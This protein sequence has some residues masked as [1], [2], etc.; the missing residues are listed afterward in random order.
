M[1]T[2]YDIMFDN[3]FVDRRLRKCFHEYLR[4]YQN[5]EALQFLIDV[6][7]FI[8]LIA[9]SSKYTSAKFIMLEYIQEGSPSEVNVS[10][11]Q[12][13]ALNEEFKKCS[14]SYCPNSLFDEV[15][16]TVYVGLKEDCFGSFVNS[17]EFSKH[18]KQTLKTD[19]NYLS[20][21]GSLKRGR[22]ILKELAKSKD[23]RIGDLDFEFG[24]TNLNCEWTNVFSTH[25]YSV[26]VSKE[27]SPS[28]FKKKKE[29]MTLPFS[30]QEVYDI[31]ICSET[32]QEILSNQ[33]RT[34]T[35]LNAVECNKYKAV[36]VHAVQS[37][38][39]LCKNIDAS[40]LCC[41]KRLD[42]GSIIHVEKSVCNPDVPE[43]KNLVRTSALTTQ[44]FENIEGGCRYTDVTDFDCGFT[45][46]LI[47]FMVCCLAK[48][49]LTNFHVILEAGNRRKEIGASGPDNL[50]MSCSLAHYDGFHVPNTK[51]S[52]C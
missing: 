40:L 44:L 28:G 32:N 29:V 41:S 50:L 5:Q 35:Y 51:S 25:D 47:N 22:Y 36:T 15:R 43:S 46:S 49:H 3:V 33:K 45:P 17:K 23:L 27:K 6:S 12:K 13:A 14:D 1:P 11:A 10:C 52:S 38:P 30:A 8:T 7:E 42:D 24:L 20:H 48:R 16:L 31:V 26:Y 18:V 2:N 34:R 37:M 21:V 19:P 4:K 9:T 39:F